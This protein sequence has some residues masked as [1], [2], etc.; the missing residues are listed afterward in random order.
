[1]RVDDVAGNIR[2]ENEMLATLYDD[3]QR[4]KRGVKMRMDDEAGNI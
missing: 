1:M 4:K 3:V 2:L